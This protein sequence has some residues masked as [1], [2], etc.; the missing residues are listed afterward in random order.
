MSAEN[1]VRPTVWQ[2]DADMAATRDRDPQAN[3]VLD[4]AVKAAI[5][6][7]RGGRPGYALFQLTQ[8]CLRAERILGPTDWS[9]RAA[10]AR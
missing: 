9:T 3:V 1:V 5:A 8:A 4:V 10:G 6:S 2:E 7:L